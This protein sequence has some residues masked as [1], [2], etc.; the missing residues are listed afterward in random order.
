VTKPEIN[1]EPVPSPSASTEFAQTHI[2]K[3]IA[4]SRSRFHMS[5]GR[6]PMPLRAYQL[7]IAD[8][9]FGQH[10]IVV[11]PTGAGKTLIAS[12]ILRCHQTPT[13]FLVPTR[14]LVEQQAAA[15]RDHTHF[16]VGEYVGGEQLPSS[17]DVLVSTP[18][19]FRIVQGN[20]R[21][22]P[23]AWAKFSCV[24]FDEVHHILKDHPYR[25]LAQSLQQ[26]GALTLCLG[27]TASLSYAVGTVLKSKSL[28]VCARCLWKCSPLMKHM[29]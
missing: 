21:V 13:L 2:E 22:G 7:R 1:S 20:G 27:L 9:C 10:S 26:S 3:K 29:C 28:C 25:K 5:T 8:E 24:V 16:T 11:L 4:A 12:E 19:A 23:F 17:F 18:E 15:I 6:V 14:F